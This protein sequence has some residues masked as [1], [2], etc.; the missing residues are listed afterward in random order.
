MCAGALIND[1][2]FFVISVSKRLWERSRKTGHPPC[3]F[4]ILFYFFVFL[5]N[6]TIL[7][8]FSP[9]HTHSLFPFLHPTRSLPFNK[10]VFGKLEVEPR[11]EGEGWVWTDHGVP[12]A[13]LDRDT[14]PIALHERSVFVLG[15]DHRLYERLWW[16]A[17][18]MWKDHG[19]PLG[20]P[21][22]S[23]PGAA[24][25]SSVFVVGTD[26][27]LYERL[28]RGDDWVYLQHVQEGGSPVACFAGYRTIPVNVTLRCMLWEWIY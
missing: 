12:G 5:P 11:A 13:L 10:I 8:R 28:Y 18:W 20:S 22:G 24:T 4:I 2:S 14:A 9:T 1:R 21:L 3:H 19:K 7:S 6:S 15:E 16:T 17:G 26:E 27:K 25:A 23:G